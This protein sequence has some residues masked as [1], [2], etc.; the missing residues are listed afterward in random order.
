MLV[1][2]FVITGNHFKDFNYV[3]LCTARSC[4]LKEQQLFE[5]YLIFTN[6]EC[7]YFWI[8]DIIFLAFYINY[9]SINYFN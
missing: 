1:T 5:I 8:S 9:I 2:L 4:F 7:E 6:T 3:L